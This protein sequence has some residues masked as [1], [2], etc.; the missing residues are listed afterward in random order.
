MVVLAVLASLV[1]AALPAVQ[2][3][4][5]SAGLAAAARD[6]LSDLQQARSEALR[7]NR[8]VAMCKSA[9]GVQCAASGGWEQGWILFHDENGNGAVDDGDDIVARREA[10]PAGFRLTGNQPVATYV[11]YTPVGA[12]K[13]TSGGFQAGTMTLC[14]LSGVPAEGRE[15]ILNALGRP[16]VQRSTVDVCA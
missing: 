11:S 5:H 14:R 8:R 12:S 3:M 9:D 6:M 1:Y 7:R 4:V 10:L 15:I 16:R 13:L 2:G